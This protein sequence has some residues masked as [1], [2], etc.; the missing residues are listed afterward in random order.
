MLEVTSLS[1]EKHPKS[2]TAKNVPILAKLLEKALDIR[3]TQLS[4][5][6]KSSYGEDDVND[7]ESQVNDMAIKMIYKLNDT[8]FR[9]LFVQLT[10]W[11]TGGLPKSDGS[12][13]LLRLTTFYKFL[14]AFFGT[15][16]VSTPK[17]CNLH[18][19]C[20]AN[21][22]LP[23]Q[24]IVTSYSSYIIE[25]TVEILK[26]A[27]C[28]DKESRSLWLATMQMLRSSFEHDQDG[29]QNAKYKNSLVPTTF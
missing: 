25:S 1:I 26:I 28:N 19:L 5:P 7:I 16:K 6:T 20:G 10:D 11:A 13:R 9:P 15:L 3:R 23:F 29:K 24:S 27:R 22:Q 21:V 8:V 2:A 4:Q 17:P 18:D 14:G 12:G